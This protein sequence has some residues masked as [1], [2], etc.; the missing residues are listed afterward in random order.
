MRY[1]LLDLAPIPE[2]SSARDA[3]ANHR[4]E[5]LPDATLETLRGLVAAA[6]QRA[7]IE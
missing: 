6:D 7:G 2:G 4:P 1:S 3:I 5:P